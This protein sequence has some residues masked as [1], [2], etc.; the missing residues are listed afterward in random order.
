MKL[1]TYAVL[2]VV[3]AASVVGCPT[4]GTVFTP[5]PADTIY[6][7][8]VDAGC[9]DPRD[10]AGLAAVQLA[11]FSDSTPGWFL[12]LRDG[13]TPTGCGFPCVGQ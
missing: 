7:E 13:G 9:V 1:L 3:L 5:V 2:V 6:A 12:C 10:D 8:L 4:N 11:V